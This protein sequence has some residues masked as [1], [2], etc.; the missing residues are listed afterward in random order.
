MEARREENFQLQGADS[1]IHCLE[2]DYQRPIH[3]PYHFHGYV[4]LLYFKQGEGTIWIGGEK[5]PFSAG[6]LYVVSAQKAH[7]LECEMPCRYICIKLQP[8]ILYMDGG[9][10][11]FALPFLTQA[12]FYDFSREETA[13]FAAEELLEQIIAEW[14]Q[15]GYGF[16]LAIRGRL[17]QLFI[18][19]L[20]HLRQT[21]RIPP[22][23]VFHPQILESLTYIQNNLD[24]VTAKTAAESCALSYHYYCRLFRDNTGKGFCEYLNDL[25]LA[26]GEKLLLSTDRS[27]TDIAHT[28]GFSGTSHFIAR[29]KSVRGVSPA[30]FRKQQKTGDDPLSLKTPN[31]CTE[32]N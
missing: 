31:G 26:E 4:E 18:Q 6:M 3:T 25:R 23:R 19:I 13:A 12:P 15:M 32:F 24:T 14:T 20:R 27:I 30:R 11:R 8:E 10:Y 7:R 9:E 29:F 28:C 16:T 17:L 5:L 1:W 21:G 2:F 22:G